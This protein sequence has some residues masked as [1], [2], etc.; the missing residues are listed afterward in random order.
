MGR[1]YDIFRKTPD[2]PPIWVESVDGLEAVKRRLLELASTKPDE[3][4]VYDH[5]AQK[6]I[7]PFG[8]PREFLQMK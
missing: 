5:R 1:I 2:N 7:D 3:Y 8:D 4:L 6:F